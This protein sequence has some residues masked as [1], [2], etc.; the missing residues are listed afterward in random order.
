MQADSMA[1]NC[2]SF[3]AI[4]LLFIINYLCFPYEELYV[5]LVGEVLIVYGMYRDS[6]L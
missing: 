5:S 2:F 4:I 6:Y 3:S 1:F